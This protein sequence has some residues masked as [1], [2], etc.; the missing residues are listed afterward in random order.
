MNR[1]IDGN[2]LDALYGMDLQ[3]PDWTP[4]F[5]CLSQV[6]R[7]P[8]ISVQAHDTMHR[9]GRVQ[10]VV[11]VSKALL[12]RY[13]SLAGDHPW[14]ERGAEALLSLGIADDR[15]LATEAELKAS[16]FHAEFMVP[17]RVGHGIALCLHHRG[18]ES[19]AVLT[20]N[21]DAPAGFYSN[22]EL[23][24][25]RALLPHLRT[26]YALQQRL[27]WLEGT[28]QSFR[29]ALDQHVDGI[30][31]LD[32]DGRVL[33]SNLAAQRMEAQRLVSR[34]PDNRLSMPW[35]SDEH[36]LLQLLNRLTDSNTAGPVVYPLHSRDGKLTG[37]CKFCSAGMLAGAQWSEFRAQ[38]IVF[39]KT[40]A[41]ASLDMVAHRLESQ[42]RFTH[43]EAHL[44]Q[45]LMQ[46][47][48]LDEAAD[49]IGVSKNTVRTQ[50]RALFNKTETRRQAELVR[51]LLQ[52][53]HL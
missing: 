52:L 17:A 21:R 14:F 39:I 36:A 29:A 44:A 48:S 37:M 34:M 1:G 45:W 9:Q 11:G 8:V 13:E 51:L 24:L 47:L 28:A 32:A 12:A 30:L 46:G 19:I 38:V 33:F 42:W 18:P 16:R 49:R 40:I 22:R 5:A 35:P 7:S 25:A 6:F 26:V 15:G 27:G 4:F 20:I 10:E 2:L 43:A 53:S 23:E 50:L 31:L 3:T 41:L